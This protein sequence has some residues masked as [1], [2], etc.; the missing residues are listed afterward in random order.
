MMGRHPR[1]AAH[2]R[3]VWPVSSCSS[4]ETPCRRQLDANWIQV[5]KL[6]F[7]VYIEVE[8]TQRNNKQMEI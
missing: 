3:A 6:G 7:R 8:E 2:M 1:R 5:H 4:R